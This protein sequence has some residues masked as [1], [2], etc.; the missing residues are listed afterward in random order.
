L[1]FVSTSSLKKTICCVHISAP[2][3]KLDKV[4]ELFGDSLM[5]G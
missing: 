5:P 3:A 4:P 1:T 2:D